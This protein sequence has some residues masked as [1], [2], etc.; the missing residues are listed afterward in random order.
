MSLE[1]RGQAHFDRTEAQVWSCRDVEPRVCARHP[2][3]CE[4]SCPTDSGP[5]SFPGKK[6]V[7]LNQARTAGP[8]V[9]RTVPQGGAGAPRRAVCSW[10]TSL[11][12][13][14]SWDVSVHQLQGTLPTW[15]V[16][17]GVALHRCPAS[18]GTPWLFPGLPLS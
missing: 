4:S 9:A 6:D 15:S 17:P 12:N 1:H 11:S 16:R 7:A 13:R 3:I 8:A 18:P 10:L 14:C 5:E 2:G